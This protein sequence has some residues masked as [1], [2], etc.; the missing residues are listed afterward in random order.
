MR[1]TAHDARETVRF[2]GHDEEAMLPDDAP[3]DEVRSVRREAHFSIALS[4]LVMA[5]LVVLAVGMSNRIAAKDEAMASQVKALSGQL[6]E[7]QKR[8]VGVEAQLVAQ[9]EVMNDVVEKTLAMMSTQITMLQG[10][11]GDITGAV[12]DQRS[13]G[14][15]VV[16][17]LKSVQARLTVMETQVA[18]LRADV[19]GIKD[20]PAVLQEKPHVRFEQRPNEDEAPSDL[21]TDSAQ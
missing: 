20:L 11:V 3:T 21:P 9:K 15:V 13:A 2:R 8:S 18:E 7:E 1:Y 16:D 17:S 6:A 12:V 4:G 5:G 19:Q 10:Q 14:K